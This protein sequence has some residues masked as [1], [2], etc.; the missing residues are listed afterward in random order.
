MLTTDYL[1]YDPAEEAEYTDLVYSDDPIYA[2]DFV[3]KRSSDLKTA[4]FDTPMAMDRHT[5]RSCIQ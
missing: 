2:D 4:L 1:V 5:P 3:V